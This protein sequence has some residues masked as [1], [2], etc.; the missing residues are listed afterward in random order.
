[1][2]SR[3]HLGLFKLLHF[4][5]ELVH[6]NRSKLASRDSHLE[7]LMSVSKQTGIYISPSQGILTLSISAKV[8]PVGSGSL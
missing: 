7:T 8:M 1:M 6:L 3:G 4:T 5:F 2:V